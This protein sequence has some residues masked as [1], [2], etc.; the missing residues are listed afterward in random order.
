MGIRHFRG[1]QEKGFNQHNAYS[2]SKLAIMM[3]TAEQAER[4]SG[5]RPTVN[6]L[7]PG[8]VNTK[9]LIAGRHCTQRAWSIDKSNAFLHACSCTTVERTCCLAM[10]DAGWQECPSNRMIVPAHMRSMEAGSSRSAVSA[11]QG[12]VLVALTSRTLIMSC[13]WSQV[14]SLPT[15]QVQFQVTVFVV[16]QGL[17]HILTALQQTGSARRV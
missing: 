13:I 4:L 2:L 15:H 7:D 3:L 16:C 12:G 1:L 8:T 6:C 14:H 17:S 9:M 5:G 11:L 10:H